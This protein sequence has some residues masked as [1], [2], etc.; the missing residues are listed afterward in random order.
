MTRI[1]S[2]EAL[3]LEPISFIHHRVGYL[4]S[5]PDTIS[6]LSELAVKNG[7]SSE[8]I[9]NGCRI[10]LR[11]ALDYD[12]DSSTVDVII[13]DTLN[14][15]Y[16]DVDGMMK[17][18]HEK[19]SSVSVTLHPSKSSSSFVPNANFSTT[20]FYNGRRFRGYG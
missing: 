5:Q 16:L 8:D 13:I 2:Q 4:I 9:T 19:A 7:Y 14:D 3:L 17:I 20:G 11:T 12:L 18:A 6:E 15:I 10:Y 1:C